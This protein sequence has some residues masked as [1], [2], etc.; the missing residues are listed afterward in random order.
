M[1]YI[2]SEH[3]PTPLPRTAVDDR[4]IIFSLRWM[5]LSPGVSTDCH[6]IALLCFSPPLV[7]QQL[8]QQWLWL[9]LDSSEEEETKCQ[10]EAFILHPYSITGS[11]DHLKFGYIHSSAG[12]L[13]T[14][15][16]NIHFITFILA[17]AFNSVCCY[18]VGY[19]WFVL[20]NSRVYMWL[21]YTWIKTALVIVWG[22]K[23]LGSVND[24]CYDSTI[25]NVVSF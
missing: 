13:L 4:M 14:W 3:T 8:L 7:L 21:Y 19:S 16:L 10:L 24:K 17:S 11:F 20:S 12:C 2:E 5:G 1:H 18:S 15:F 25:W 23:K 6:N 22:E 9:D